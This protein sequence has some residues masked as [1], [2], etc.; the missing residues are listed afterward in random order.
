LYETADGWVCVVAPRADEQRAL[1]DALGVEAVADDERQ[2][3]RLRV[4]FTTV[5]TRD[6][7]AQLHTAGVAA[8]EPVGRNVHAYMNDADARRTR[9]V[10]EVPHPRLGNVRELDVL[11]RV[12]DASMPPHRL[13][14]GLGEHTDELLAEW[15]CSPAEIEGL[16]ASGAV[17]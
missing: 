12:S 10:A 7:V 14:P 13:A 16:R 17:R 3:D 2:G 6:V 11:V 15:G 8:V 1:L 4:A 5:K 9:R